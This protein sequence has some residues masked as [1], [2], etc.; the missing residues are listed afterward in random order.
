MNSILKSFKVLH[1]SSINSV[2]ELNIQLYDVGW[3]YS[4]GKSRNVWG[5]VKFPEDLKTYIAEYVEQTGSY[6]CIW[7]AYDKI[8]YTKDKET[9]KIS[10]H[11][12]NLPEYVSGTF[13]C[14][15]KKYGAL[16]ENMGMKIAVAL[17]MPTTYNFLVKFTP[18]LH[19][20][21]TKH[22]NQT[23]EYNDYIN[24]YGVVSINM[25]QSEKDHIVNLSETLPKIPAY[26]PD[27]E[28]VSFN[29]NIV[30]LYSKLPLKEDSR[31]NLIDFWEDAFQSVADHYVPN[32]TDAE[33][34]AR[35]KHF[36]SRLARSF[37]LREFIGDC[38][39]S[40]YNCGFI[41]N[42]DAK[43]F[44]LSPN[45][46]FGEAFNSLVT[47][48]MTDDE[49]SPTALSTILFYQPN[50]LEIKKFRKNASIATLA[51]TFSNDTAQEN[52]RHVVTHSPEDLD[53]F[54]TNLN[55]VVDE[56]ILTEIIYSY[57]KPNEYGDCLLSKKDAEM[58]D[59][60]ITARAA[61]ITAES[62]KILVEDYTQKFVH[63]LYVASLSNASPKFKTEM[64]RKVVQKKF[65][66]LPT[67]TQ[68]KANQDI[69]VDEKFDY[70]V[71][72]CGAESVDNMLE[73]IDRYWSRPAAKQFQNYFKKVTNNDIITKDVAKHL[74]AEEF[75]S[76]V[77]NDVFMIQETKP[78]FP[79]KTTEKTK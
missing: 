41:C 1:L 16:V 3:D 24:E 67:E 12:E 35:I 2:Q 64:M 61:W 72:I 36:K 14:S 33:K 43:I 19:E 54:L 17:G 34:Q 65:E 56:N 5:F 8:A 73:F 26:Q 46:D 29:N 20:K 70:V 32:M 15:K 51:S 40:S 76:S 55:R 71:K 23:G 37:L 79:Q 10:F 28:L 48:K 31:S 62:I 25:L 39:F 75:V 52:L 58:F 22:I 13:K 74:F 11:P 49:L 59:A 77:Y 42:S 47:S 66:T 53:E 21:I 27:E 78:L 50:F 30:K 44:H 57:T 6:P 9:G 68:E 7:T 38:D 4:G 63:D 69:S 18:D 60:Y 45:F